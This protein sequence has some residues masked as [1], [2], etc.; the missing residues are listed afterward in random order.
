[1]IAID[2]KITAWERAE[3]E[4][5]YKDAVVQ[6]MKE[7]K[8]QSA[9]DLYHFVKEL[10]S[11]LGSTDINPETTE[12]MCVEENGMCSTIEVMDSDGELVWDNTKV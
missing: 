5:Q 6:A 2:F 11:D 3:I 10:G 8:I 1:M 7:G 9:D 4:E 12:Q